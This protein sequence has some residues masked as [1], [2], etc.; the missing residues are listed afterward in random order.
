MVAEDGP[1]G[2]RQ[3]LDTGMVQ[4][5]PVQPSRHRHSLGCSQKPWSGLQPARHAAMGEGEAEGRIMLMRAGSGG[6]E[7]EKFLSASY[8]PPCLILV[9]DNPL[10]QMVL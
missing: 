2:V 10:G 6:E 5:G 9:T 7:A 1:L 3:L 8:A 4:R